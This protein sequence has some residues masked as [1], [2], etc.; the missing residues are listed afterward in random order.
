MPNYN[1]IEVTSDQNQLNVLELN[2][3]IGF[4]HKFEHLNRVFL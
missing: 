3:E 4:V 1:Q 2:M